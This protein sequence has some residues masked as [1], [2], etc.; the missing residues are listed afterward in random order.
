MSGRGAPLEGM[1]SRAVARGGAYVL[2][3]LLLAYV[4]WTL[5]ALG[6]GASEG[7]GLLTRFP[8]LLGLAPVLAALAQ[9]VGASVGFLAFDLEPRDAT[10]A[11][12]SRDR[13]LAASLVTA[14]GGVAVVATA[15]WHGVLAAAGVA[16]VAALLPPFVLAGRSLPE[17]LGGFVVERRRRDDAVDVLPWYQRPGLALTLL[18]LGLTF[19]VGARIV[20]FA[21]GRLFE[22]SQSVRRLVKDLLDF[23]FS[24]VPAVIERM[25][26]TIF[27]ALLASALALPFA[28]GLA[29]VGARNLTRGSLGGKGGYALA[30]LLMNVTRSIE[31]LVWVIIFS[32]WVG[33]GPFAGLLALWV[34]SVAALGKLYSEAIEDIDPGPMEA[35]Q[36]TGARPLAVLRYGVVPQVVPPFLGFTVYRWDINVRMATI[37][38]LV[39]GG[40]IGDRLIYYQQVGQWP[41]VGTILLFI[42]GVVWLMDLASSKVRERLL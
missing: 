29:F 1:W 32:I 33:V 6:L 40:G 18:V 9:G 5:H 28:F 26:E 15:A 37:L 41:K 20:G 39:G 10:G 11:R 8:L 3:V 14:L 16:L 25:V 4:L 2:D 27:V 34:H 31:P 42:T 36:A 21:P 38:G 22:D 24:I 19:A 23:D 7:Q 13:R 30:R 17:R 35:L 12:A